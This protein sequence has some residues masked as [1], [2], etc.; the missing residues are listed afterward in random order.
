[1]QLKHKLLFL[2]SILF[3]TIPFNY[4]YSAGVDGKD[5]QIEELK[6]RI[7]DLSADKNKITETLALQTEINKT[8]LEKENRIISNAGNSIS[9]ISSGVTIIS[10]IITVII[11]ASSIFSIWLQNSKFKT[12]E[13]NLKYTKDEFDK[14]KND[15][16]KAYDLLEK[17]KS[18][19]ETKIKDFE[20]IK[21]KVMV[22]EI[23]S[24][25]SE[26]KAK[27]SEYFNMALKS[28]DPDEQIKYY[29]ECINLDPDN[30][31]AFNNIGI[32]FSDKKEYEKAIENYDK[33]IKIKKDFASAYNNRGNAYRNKKEYDKSIDDYNKAIEFK[34]D[35]HEAFNNKGIVYCCLKKFEDA[36]IN[37]SKSIEL[38]PDNEITIINLK[39]LYII[40]NEFVK[41]VNT[42]FDNFKLTGNELIFHFLN[43]TSKTMKNE[44]AIFEINKINELLLEKNL[45]I[46]WTFDQFEK[47]LSTVEDQTKKAKIAEVMNRIK[48]KK[49]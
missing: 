49:I 9:T 39:E 18:V 28:E 36:L 22:M 14:K 21:D 33:A 8:L 27:A 41:S 15:F 10:I 3:L 5:K 23:N 48:E 19:F 6:K 40:A 38:N 11:L 12:L 34:H 2:I 32:A 25:E 42:K 30:A 20:D 44:D 24:K 4:C 1:M 35:Y 43:F 7:D 31:A 29:T 37:F 17:T 13:D 26:K 46:E 16:E 47:W 45:K